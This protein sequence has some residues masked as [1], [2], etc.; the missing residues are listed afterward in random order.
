MVN[1]PSTLFQFMPR[2]CFYEKAL[3]K[4]LSVTIINL[5]TL[6][7]KVTSSTPDHRQE[8]NSYLVIM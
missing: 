5:Q 6:S 7:H 8:I 4:H 1:T 2:G 3:E